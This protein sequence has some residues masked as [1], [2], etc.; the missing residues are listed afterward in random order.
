MAAKIID[1]KKI[2]A[3]IRDEIKK[4]IIKL[5][6][7]P[8]LAVI[9]VG[10]DPSSHLYVK[11][12]ER[13]CA[14]VGIYFER[15][16][17]FATEPEEK[18]IKKIQELNDKPN[19]HGILVQLP[20][21]VG[22]DENKIITS[23][24]PQ[25]DVDGFHP[26]NIKKLLTGRPEIMPPIF[27]G[28]LKLIESTNTELINKKIAVLANSEIFAKPLAKIFENNQVAIA[29]SPTKPTPITYDA[30]I[31]IT[32]LGRPKFLTAEMIK[33]GAIIIDVGTTR[34][35]NGTLVG[36]ADFES[37]SQ[38]AGWLTPVPGGVGPM[39]V[40]MLLQNVLEI[41]KKKEPSL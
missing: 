28:I 10:A 5:G 30:D 23:I 17:F 29:I 40:V 3:E 26:E 36:D 20:L 2:A 19:V 11:L 4:E 22:Y 41:T 32:A 18:I 6:I 37:V 12:K 1:G 39:T 8:G 35:E 33:E 24:N 13:A 21:P 25:K 38:K 31:I 14:E 16:L 34:L 15:H 27:K 9:L 7:K